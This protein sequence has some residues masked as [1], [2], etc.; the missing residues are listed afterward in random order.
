MK[1]LRISVKKNQISQISASKNQYQLTYCCCNL[2]VQYKQIKFKF[3]CSN[4][5]LTLL[6]VA[7]Q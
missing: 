3:W 7:V 4:F 6:F 5:H 1:M 2:F